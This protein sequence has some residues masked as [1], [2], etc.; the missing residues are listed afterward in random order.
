SG[1]HDEVWAA[2]KE[3][4]RLADAGVPYGEI[5]VVA[6][7]LDPYLDLVDAVFREHAIPYVSSGR[8]RLDR[9]P[10][11]KTARLLFT[12]ED[13]D[14]G[15]V[16]DLLRSPF[17][18]RS[19]GDPELWDAASRLMGIGHGAEEWRRR[20][21][22]AAGKDWT[23]APAARAGGRRFVLP[24]SEVDLFWESVRGLIEAPPPPETG[25]T[26][27]AAWAVD[28]LRRFLEPDPRI[29]GAVKALESLEGF[30]LDDP[31][32]TLLRQLAQLSEPAGG[33]AGVQ[34]LDAMAARGL[35]FRALVVVG[36]NE[37]VFPRFILEDAFLRDAVRSRL[38]A[39]LGHRLPRKQDG[40]D[41]ERLLFEMLRG[42]SDEIV[43]TY[44][45]SDDRGRLQIASHYLPS[46]KPEQVPRRPSDRLREAPFDR[47]TPRE[48]SLR[49][50]QGEALGRALGWDVETLVNAQAFLERIEA[51][52]APGGCDGLVDTRQYW[53]AVAGFGLSPSAL[54]RLAECPFRFFA[55][56]ML[57]LEELEEPE[58]EDA[59]SPLDVGLIYHDVLERFHRHGDLD[60]QMEAAF[61]AF[62]AA[63]SI[64]YPVLWE[65]ERE[66]MR[67]VLRAFVDADDCTVY[68]PV[69]FERELKAALPLAVGGR[70][71]VVFRGFVDRLDAGPDGSFRVIDY[72]KSKGK[73]PWK[74]ETGVF[75]KG[76]YLQPPI[77]FLLAQ[78]VLG[79]KEPSSCRF[80]YYFLEQV[81]EGD[82]WEMTLEGESM[83]ERWDE[84]E[85]HL[86][87]LLET[88]PAGRFAIRPGDYCS[89]CDYRTMCRKSHLP[90]RLRA[91]DASLFPAPV[92]MKAPPAS[93][94]KR[95]GKKS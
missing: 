79:V 53:A 24:Q 56:R 60:R 31:L 22:A 88:I 26:A 39:R 10:R 86:K 83:G 78:A 84:L 13:F 87:R 16:L 58:G 19:G 75:E 46:V 9:D 74:M 4:L 41:E 18:R 92:L 80:S 15:R 67:K 66:R 50:G 30:A 8:R 62:E 27:Y 59:L 2:A 68:K 43:L 51:R 72:K 48:A 47:L 82:P 29:E 77:Y 36:M 73:Y 7:T 61:E 57:D 21:G 23:H 94:N 95:K 35:A 5:G 11:V 89:G 34:V 42:A 44:Q 71:D 20:L 40:Y 93:V 38:T 25:W 14:R 17:F 90:T 52:G 33:T 85:A 65:V 91:Q 3:V 63:R 32:E 37:R 69:D 55:S 49:T 70:K 28:R 76:R 1:A 54:E 45:R 12:L 81:V 6:R 64:R